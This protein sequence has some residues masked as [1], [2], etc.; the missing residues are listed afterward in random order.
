MSIAVSAVLKPSRLLQL[1]VC[2]IGLFAVSLFTLIWMNWIGNFS[3]FSRIV[4]AGACIVATATCLF[5]TSGNK[6]THRIDISNV[7]QIRLTVYQARHAQDERNLNGDIVH[8]MDASTLWPQFILLRLQSE[9]GC[10][11]LL[12]IFPDCVSQESFRALL[13]ACRWIAAHGNATD[14]KIL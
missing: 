7:G 13:I 14:K 4:I 11:Q 5:Y 3:F 2:A 12:R 8:M 6:K 10:M 1:M 9:N